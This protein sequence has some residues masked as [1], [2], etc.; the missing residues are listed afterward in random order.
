MKDPLFPAC[1]TILIFLSITNAPPLS[2]SPMTAIHALQDG[3]F[4]GYSTMDLF[5]AFFFSALI[6]NQ[7]Q[8]KLKATND[9]EV[10]RAALKPSLIGSCLLGLIYLG[11]VFL[12]AHYQ[13]LTS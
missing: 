7:I 1:L 9:K 3:F 13:A 4:I 6:F 10:L 2:T 11:F 8:A 12:G 5:A